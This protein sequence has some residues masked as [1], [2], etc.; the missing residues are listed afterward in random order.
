MELVIGYGRG[1]GGWTLSHNEFSWLPASATVAL[2]ASSVPDRGPMSDFVPVSITH[3][4][5]AWLGGLGWSTGQ[6]RWDTLRT[7]AL[8]WVLTLPLAAA[9]GAVTFALAERIIS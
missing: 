4:G 3:V 5:V 6:A 8:S 7:I 9:L 1:A 2:W